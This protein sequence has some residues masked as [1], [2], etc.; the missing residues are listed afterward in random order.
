MFE[1]IK[2]NPN[3]LFTLIDKEDI[4]LAEKRM[5][6]KIPT[7]LKEF[8]ENIGCGVLQSKDHSFNRLIDPLTCAD[9]RMRED[10]YEFDPDLELYENFEEDKMIFFEINEGVYA[11]I[12]LSDD[13]RHKI[14]FCD[15][16]IA[17]S[18]E[19]FLEKIVEACNYWD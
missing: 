10:I 7:E 18:L 6:I 19:E 15:E 4:Q 17:Y 5:N 9:I 1:K 14:Y 16:V 2:N 11:L 13:F 3:N 8:Y 12:E